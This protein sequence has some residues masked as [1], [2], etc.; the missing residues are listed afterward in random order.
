[1]HAFSE[2]YDIVSQDGEEAFC[3]GIED[4]KDSFMRVSTFKFALRD[5]MTS[6]LIPEFD[7]IE[8]WW[9]ENPDSNFILMILDEESEDGVWCIVDSRKDGISW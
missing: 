8:T 5:G 4:F 1:M 6:L 7:E 9:T 3:M 2:W